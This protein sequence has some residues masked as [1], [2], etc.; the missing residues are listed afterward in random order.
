MRAQDI[1]AVHRYAAEHTGPGQNQ[2]ERRIAVDGWLV[3]RS[4]S[5][6]TYIRIGAFCPKA[7]VIGSAGL[8]FGPSKPS[9]HGATI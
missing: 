2:Y 4:R 1:A 7:L 3:A 8:A 6:S 9:S 5:S